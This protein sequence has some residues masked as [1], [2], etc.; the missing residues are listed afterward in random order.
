MRYAAIAVAALAIGAGAFFGLQGGASDQITEQDTASRQQQYEVLVAGSGMQVDMVGAE[1]MDQAIETMP[2][3]Q[4]QKTELREQ[5]QTGQVRLAWLTLWDTH[6]EDG[7]I[8]R[9]E[10][11]AAVPVEVMALNAPT[12]LAI[13]FPA[14][15]T[16]KVTG[17]V[18]GGGGITIALKSGSAQI[19][20]PT[21]RPG[22]TLDLPVTPGL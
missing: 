1:E 13:P 5:V 3:S 11:D 12:T 18:D 2:V 9:F 15:G 16:V 20:W 6:A 14:S 17:V 22:D 21:M 8:L 19:A 4:E 10:S 7:D